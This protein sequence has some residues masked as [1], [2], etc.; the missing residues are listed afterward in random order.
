MADIG[1]KHGLGGIG[2]IRVCFRT[3]YLINGRRQFPRH[4]VEGAGEVANFPCVT[5][6]V[7]AVTEVSGPEALYAGFEPQQTGVGRAYQQNH[8]QHGDGY[9]GDEADN[10]DPIR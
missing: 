2:G 4:V 3:V 7:D 5:I 6:F 10:R 1:Q 8:Q 9:G